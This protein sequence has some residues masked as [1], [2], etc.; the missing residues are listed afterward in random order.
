M[1]PRRQTSTTGWILAASAAAWLTAAA[2]R[3]QANA[4]A[5]AALGAVTTLEKFAVTGSYLP[6]SAL[7]PAMPVS[8]LTSDEMDR[9]GVVGSLLDVLRKTAPQFTGNGNLGVNNANTSGGVN[10]GGTQISFRNLPTL[11]LLNGRRLP[12]S[13]V[14]STGGGLF[15]DVN[16]IPVAA[17]GKVE[18]VQDGGSA[19]YG[20]DA[21]AGVVNI[22][23]KHDLQGFEVRGKYSFSKNPGHYA[24]RL[25][26]IAGGLTRGP[27][28]LT[29]AAEW[30][31]S[32]PL[33]L[34]QRSFS[35]PIYG[36]SSFAGILNIGG[37]Y[38]YLN[39]SLTKPPAGPTPIATLVANGVYSGPYTSTEVQSF[40]DV[41]GPYGSTL[42]ASNQRK[43]ATLAVDHKF[44]D[45][46]SFFG[47]ALVARTDTAYRLN[48]QGFSDSWATRPRPRSRFAIVTT[49]TRAST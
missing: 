8:T 13:P 28:S 15:V 23:L 19:L 39:P 41:A 48:A 12:Y 6:Q 44:N 24:E 7:A 4:P 43:S 3:A 26:S 47:S 38:Y 40:Y 14:S 35:R 29:V 20:S 33:Y 31:K 5:A 18:I 36:T 49:F 45:R 9:T 16:M 42:Q 37:A 30:F 22:I 25:V 32:D 27:T 34:S 46:V 11:V 10:N 2:A 21:I 17:I 1:A